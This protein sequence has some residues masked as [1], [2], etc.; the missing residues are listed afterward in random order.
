MHANKVLRREEESSRKEE[1]H[2]HLP[3]LR[4]STV[5]LRL[6]VTSDHLTVSLCT[7]K[8]HTHTHTC[9]N[10]HKPHRREKEEGEHS[11]LGVQKTEK[12]LK[13]EDSQL[14][15]VIATIICQER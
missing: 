6:S 7:F 3:G 5:C 10:T 8:T 1:E 15:R 11:V 2:R 13:T 9:K 14:Q 12:A 4:L